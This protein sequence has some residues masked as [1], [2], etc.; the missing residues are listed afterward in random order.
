MRDMEGKICDINEE[1]RLVNIN[2]NLEKKYIV[3]STF[4][5]I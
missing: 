2:Y 3:L 5:K 1:V 4:L